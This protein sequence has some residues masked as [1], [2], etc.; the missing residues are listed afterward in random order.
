MGM[1][2]PPISRPKD[3]RKIGLKALLQQTEVIGFPRSAVC[4]LLGAL[5]SCLPIKVPEK[6]DYTI[7]KVFFNCIF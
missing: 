1:I 7:E 3:K 4:D 6:A 2:V 5:K